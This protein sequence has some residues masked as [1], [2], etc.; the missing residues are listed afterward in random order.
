VIKLWSYIFS[1]LL[2]LVSCTSTRIIQ[3]PRSNA[4]TG[5]SFY[6]QA[7]TYKWQQRDSLS[8]TVILQGAMPDFLRKF[9]RVRTHYTDSSNNKRYRAIYF[10]APDYLSVGS[11][12]DWARIHITPF[13]AQELADSLHCF[14]PTRKMV[15]QIYQSANVKLAPIPLTKDRDSTPTFYSHHLSVEVQRKGRT[16]LIAGIQ[17]DI[18][19][20]GRLYNSPKRDRVA[21][22]GWH[23]LDGKPIQPLYTGH[24]Y[25]Y[26][27]YSQGVRL[28]YEKIK[29]NGKWM[30]YSAVFGDPILKNLLCDEV[31][32]GNGR[33]PASLFFSAPNT[34]IKD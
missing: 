2:I 28:V 23:Q 12:I 24:V 11:D 30:H 32:C 15:D 16:G 20:T 3:W 1:L 31:D 14:L 25:W 21:I 19:T 18:V 26:V 27:D 5:S 8:K 9:A 7:S 22:Y 6:V 17:K 29:V 10:V 34:A 13:L 4:V 33:Y